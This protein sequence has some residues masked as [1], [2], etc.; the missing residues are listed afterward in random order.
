MKFPFPLLASVLWFSCS[1]PAEKTTTTVVQADVVA[2]QTNPEGSLHPVQDTDSP[3]IRSLIKSFYVEKE[4]GN[5]IYLQAYI[6]ISDINKLVAINEYLRVRYQP[7]F[8]EALDIWYFDKP[9]LV[10]KY[11]SAMD[12]QTISNKEFEHLDR[13]MVCQY[14]QLGQGEGSFDWNAIAN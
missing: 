5:G 3:S 9:H 12:N 2:K 14:S 10:N 13:H 4:R 1:Q 11:L 7:R 6:Y 8:T